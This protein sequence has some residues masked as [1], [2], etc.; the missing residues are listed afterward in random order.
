MCEYVWIV[1]ESTCV[2][3]DWVCVSVWIGL[4]MCVCSWTKYSVSVSI[5]HAN[6]Y[7]WCVVI[8]MSTN[9]A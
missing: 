2:C 7:I 9:S 6:V 5:V 8:C 4:C 1:F 3:I